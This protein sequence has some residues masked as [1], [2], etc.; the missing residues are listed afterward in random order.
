MQ[1]SKGELSRFCGYGNNPSKL[2][3]VFRAKLFA[4]TAPELADRIGEL[5]KR[6]TRR[7]KLAGDPIWE[8]L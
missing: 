7:D 6:K 2:D 8:R 3:D 4:Q 5:D 1:M